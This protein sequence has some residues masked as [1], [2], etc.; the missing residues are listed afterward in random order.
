MPG[1]GRPLD[2]LGH[3]IACPRTGLLARRAKIVEHAWVRV[4]REAIGPE[5]QVVPQQWLTHTTAPGVA[6]DDRRRLD[7]VIYGI[8]L[9]R[10][11]SLS[12]V[13]RWPTARALN[14][15]TTRREE[16][17]YPELLR[18]GP[19]RLVVVGSEVGSRSG[20][21][22]LPVVREFV[23]LRHAAAAAWARRW[24]TQLSVAAQRATALSAADW[25]WLAASRAAADAPAFELVLDLADAA[26]RSMLPFRA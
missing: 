11:L 22:A 24:W 26:G 3:A 13:T 16:A 17:T 7:M 5:G 1:C 10:D 14:G 19:Q 18:N 21:G 8:T 20:T 9:R 23:R 25:A 15:Y 6:S 4:A 2:P 12:R